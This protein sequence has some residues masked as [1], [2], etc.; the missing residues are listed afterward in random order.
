[1]SNRIRHVC[2]AALS[3]TVALVAGDA[4]AEV[5]VVVGTTS[6]VPALATDEAADLFMVRTTKLPSGGTA[7]VSCKAKHTTL[8]RH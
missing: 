6:P 2:M 7:R 8:K 3:L 5:A 1:M 4:L